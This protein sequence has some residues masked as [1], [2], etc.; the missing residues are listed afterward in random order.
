MVRVWPPF[1]SLL[2]AVGSILASF[3]LLFGAFLIQ[4]VLLGRDSINLR[5]PLERFRRHPKTVP[6]LG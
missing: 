2:V 5:G 1:G 6:V 3:G 4:F